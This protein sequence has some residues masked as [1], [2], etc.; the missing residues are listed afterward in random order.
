MFCTENSGKKTMD[1]DD[2]LKRVRE[3]EDYIRC[4]KC[5]NSLAKFLAKNSDGVENSVIARLLMI[6]EDKVEEIYQ[7]AVEK[8]RAEMVDQDEN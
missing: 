2:I 4:P 1:R 7:E 3:E 8:L 5:S 6:P